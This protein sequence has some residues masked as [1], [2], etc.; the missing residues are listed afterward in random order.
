MLF[1]MKKIKRIEM[2]LKSLAAQSVIISKSNLELKLEKD[3]LIHTEY[4]HKYRLSQI[5]DLLM[6]LDLN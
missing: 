2:Y 3:E 1:T 5:H 6:M 4:S